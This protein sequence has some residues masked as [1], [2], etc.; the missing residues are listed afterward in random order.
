MN[1]NSNIENNDDVPRVIEIPV[2][3]FSVP[4]VTTTSSNSSSG[5]TSVPNHAGTD[6]FKN[7]Q[8]DFF[9][10]QPTLFDDFQSP[11]GNLKIK[12]KINNIE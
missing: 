7:Q 2:Q 5:P 3:H 10:R 12:K 6:H 4:I 9:I 1:S 8:N 11:F